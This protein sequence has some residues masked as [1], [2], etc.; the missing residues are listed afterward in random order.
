M[1]FILSNF[2]IKALATLQLL[3]VHLQLFYQVSIEIKKM[4]KFIVLLCFIAIVSGQ[5]T[6][7][8]TTMTPCQ[9]VVVYHDQLAVQVDAI[10]ATVQAVWL[11]DAQVQYDQIKNLTNQCIAR[12]INYDACTALLIPL[13][14]MAGAQQD[15]ITALCF[16]KHT[17]LDSIIVGCVAAT[18]PTW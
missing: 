5:D 10:N 2:S 15:A 6:T 17:I 8:T 11:A 18:A 3:S 4:F 16:G 7:T 13:A 14:T 1:Y 12:N 9:A